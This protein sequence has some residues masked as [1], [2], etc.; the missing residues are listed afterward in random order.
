MRYY[1]YQLVDPRTNKPFYIGKG[2]GNRMYSHLAEAKRGRHKWSNILKCERIQ[3]ILR[4]GCEITYKVESRL[5]ESKALQKEKQLLERYGLIVN[6]TGILTNIR[7]SGQHHKTIPKRKKVRRVCQYSLD[8]KQIKIYGSVTA[9]ADIMG[10]H[11]TGILG[12]CNGIRQTAHGYVWKYENDPF[13]QPLNEIEYHVQ[14]RKPIAQYKENTLISKFDSIK[15]ASNLT[16]V[17]RSGIRACCVGDQKTAG[18]F[19]WKLL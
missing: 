18:G 5:S 12:C 6:D 11:K 19:V 3:S 1:V 13:Q 15:E 8:G 16:R 7:K 2:R 17:H 14:R 10:K 4:Q 9:A